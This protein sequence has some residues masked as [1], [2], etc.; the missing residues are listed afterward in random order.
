MLRRATN[1]PDSVDALYKITDKATAAEKE[2]L[3]AW[4]ISKDRC[5]CSNNAQWRVE[6]GEH[7]AASEIIGVIIHAFIAPERGSLG[8]HHSRR[9]LVERI[10][11]EF[12]CLI[13]SAILW[14]LRGW[15]IG[16]GFHCKDPGDFGV[17]PIAS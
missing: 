10:S 14:R 17:E 4:L 1:R 7:F 2:Q 13:C 3:V 6:G 11:S 16:H 5:I 15:Q 12:V 8:Y 9:E